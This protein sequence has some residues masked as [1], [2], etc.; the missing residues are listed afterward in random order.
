VITKS[1]S[2]FERR[3][4]AQSQVHLMT[5]T[6]GLRNLGLSEPAT[7]TCHDTLLRSH[8]CYCYFLLQQQQRLLVQGG[9]P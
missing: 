3:S 7:F 2:Q 9:P 8:H 6:V 5:C 1:G 4:T